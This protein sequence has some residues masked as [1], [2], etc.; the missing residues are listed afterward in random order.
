MEGGRERGW[1]EGGWE[2]SNGVFVL[3]GVT[4]KALARAAQLSY[5]YQTQRISREECVCVC[6]CVCVCARARARVFICEDWGMFLQ[7]NQTWHVF[8]FIQ[9]WHF[10]TAFSPLASLLLVLFLGHRWLFGLSVHH[11]QPA[12]HFSCPI[13]LS[14]LVIWELHVVTLGASNVTLQYLTFDYTG[15]FWQN[16][17]S[18]NSPEIITEII[19]VRLYKSILKDMY[20][21]L[22]FT[23]FWVNS[24]NWELN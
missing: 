18:Q 14:D 5:R 15:V 4:H 23:W 8:W 9:S 11:R 19:T 6:V 22:W 2:C 7:P 10:N 21:N 16:L 13:T 20:E 1:R 3:V 12:S 24:K 17:K